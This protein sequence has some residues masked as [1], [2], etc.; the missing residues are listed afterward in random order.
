MPGF[1]AGLVMHKMWKRNAADTEER[2]GKKKEE[3]TLM[4][5]GYRRVPR[6]EKDP[7]KGGRGGECLQGKTGT[8]TKRKRSGESKH[9]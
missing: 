5:I 7:K 1:G 2:R 8:V 6:E 3:D 9:L 4:S